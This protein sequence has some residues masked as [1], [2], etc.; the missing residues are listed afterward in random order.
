MGQ[1]A[2]SQP[3][4][5]AVVVMAER[6]WVMQATDG[7]NDLAMFLQ[8]LKGP[9]K[10]VVFAGCRDLIVQRMHA[11]GEIDKG[12]ALGRCRLSLSRSQRDHAFQHG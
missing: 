3:D 12:T 7:R 6:P 11:V 10:L 8:R 1:L 9:R 5:N 4:R 2:A